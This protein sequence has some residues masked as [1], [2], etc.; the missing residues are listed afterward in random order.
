[1]NDKRLDLEAGGSS[2]SAPSARAPGGVVCTTRFAGSQPAG[3]VVRT[4]PPARF[5]SGPAGGA[6]RGG[7]G[8]G[9]G[10]F[11][12]RG[13]GHS[14][15]SS[16]SH[17]APDPASIRPAPGGP[18]SALPSSSPSPTLAD[19]MNE[20]R[21]LRAENVAVTGRLS[22]LER[23]LDVSSSSVGSGAGS[24]APLAASSPRPVPAPRA[25]RS[26][27]APEFRSVDFRVT[28]GLVGCVTSV[29]ASAE[30]LEEERRRRQ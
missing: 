1:M 15:S 3:R 29:A 22:S 23:S 2:R 13:R 19:V 11:R 28:E 7:S 16:R 12:G 25:S 8:G 5:S 18:P 21:N 14:S 6:G 30:E 24:G 20:L 4:G 27:P 9:R 10:D 17:T 26:R